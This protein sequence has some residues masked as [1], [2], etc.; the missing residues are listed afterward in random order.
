MNFNHFDLPP[1]V[2]D[3]VGYLIG[4]DW[5]SFGR[6]LGFDN[7]DFQHI[8][9]QTCKLS[10]KT[11]ILL[12]NF[13]QKNG[14]LSWNRL[15]Q[16]LSSFKRLDAITVIEKSPDL[17]SDLFKCAE[18]K[19]NV[20]MIPY[21]CIFMF[22]SRE[23]CNEVKFKLNH[24]HDYQ[25]SIRNKK[26][27]FGYYL[28]KKKDNKLYVKLENLVYDFKRIDFKFSFPDTNKNLQQDLI[29][30]IIIGN[31]KYEITY[32]GL[33]IATPDPV[34]ECDLSKKIRTS[35]TLDWTKNKIT[36]D[37]P[38]ESY[39]EDY[40][41]RNFLNCHDVITFLPSSYDNDILTEILEFFNV[42]L[43]KNNEGT[44]AVLPDYRLYYHA[45]LLEC[46]VDN[47]RDCDENRLT[48]F[49]SEHNLVIIAR[50]ATTLDCI[51]LESE[52]CFNDI[53]LFINV[54][55]PLIEASKL[56][57]LG[58]VVLPFFER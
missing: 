28:T 52:N 26:N 13:K 31:Y 32:N 1:K 15:K 45:S 36:F 23:T 44:C 42:F 47:L 56:I 14:S 35:N 6:N 38:I 22:N 34:F 49:C 3:R 7:I 8:D 46:N 29:N 18:K 58:V 24:E 19:R 54:Y 48:I 16:E 33:I 9:S 27:N 10:E 43:G 25:K 30:D 40:I 21:G 53:I 55:K 4:D 37:K 11:V 41:Y 57:I 51:E 12:K 39:A 17:F 50:I 5:K 2:Y 20:R